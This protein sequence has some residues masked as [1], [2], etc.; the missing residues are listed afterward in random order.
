MRLLEH[1]S[2][3]WIAPKFGYCWVNTN[4][5]PRVEISPTKKNILAFLCKICFR[6]FV[7]KVLW[8][9]ICSSSPSNIIEKI[10]VT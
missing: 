1:N 3:W 6:D 8:E 4:I 9:M 2:S 7:W 10:H 5:D